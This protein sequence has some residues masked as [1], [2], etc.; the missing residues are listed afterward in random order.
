MIR[1]PSQSVAAALHNYRQAIELLYSLVTDPTGDRVFQHKSDPT[2]K[3]EH[4][5]RLARTTD[6][7]DFAGNPQNRYKTVHI[8]GTSGKG[9]VAAMVA[10][11][12]TQR[13]LQTGLHI[14]PYLQIPN[15]KLIVN[16]QM[17][18]PSNFAQ[19][20]RQL[21]QLR[22][23]WVQA[24]RAFNDLRYGEAWVALTYLWF[25]WQQVDWAVMETGLGGRYD[26]TNVVNSELAMITN[27]NFDHLKSLGPALLDIAHHKA[28]IIKPGGLAITSETNPEVIDLFKR[29]AAQKQAKL[30]I[31][32][33]DFD[34]TTP[35]EDQRGVIINVS[36]P[37]NT[38]QDVRVSLPGRFQACNAALAIAG[39]DVLVGHGKLASLSQ[40]VGEAL[41]TLKFPGR[42]E[43]VQESPR[44]ILD[45][46][47]NL[48]KIEA[49]VQSLQ[50]TY[51]TQKI[52]AI[53][54]MMRVK[55]AEGIILQLASLVSRFIFTAPVVFGK[56][57]FPPNE[58]AAIARKIAPHV[59]AHIAESVKNS[60]EYA[61]TILPPDELLL[62]TGSI[63][64]AGEARDHWFPRDELLKQLA[65]SE[66]QG[67]KATG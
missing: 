6:F 63:Y 53:V 17:A 2:V 1:T 10:A 5:E 50:T 4:G 57:S 45:G 56:R 60:V 27:V 20:V 25:A 47:H 3:R 35:A 58:L 8:A 44:V 11:L 23:E 42:M 49:L 22:A 21:M 51:P 43:I 14:S 55:N 19:S 61:L 41:S 65:T 32:G 13:G 34:Y 37:F 26:P 33:R 67:S 40:P 38:Y 59:E 29:E 64:L 16:G 30:Y 48:H 9:S 36:G 66:L 31:L 62:V 18:S 24:N 28:G 39:L 15:E 12:L 54:G 7:L 46:A 52:T